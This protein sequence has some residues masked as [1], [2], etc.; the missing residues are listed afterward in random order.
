MSIKNLTTINPVRYQKDKRGNL[1]PVF[2]AG[3]LD[4]N[5]YAKLTPHERHNKE[6]LGNKDYKP[7]EKD[8]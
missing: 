8:K 7:P 4:K 3:Q 6:Q 5:K 1:I 2:R